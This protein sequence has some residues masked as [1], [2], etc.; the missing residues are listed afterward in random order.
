MIHP[1]TRARAAGRARRFAAAAVLGVAAAGCGLWAPLRES[2]EP[3]TPRPT[4]TLER[5]DALSEA[6]K[7]TATAGADQ[8][9]PGEQ[10][11][12]PGTNEAYPADQRAAGGTDEAHPPGYPPPRPTAGPTVDVKAT[13]ESRRVAIAGVLPVGAQFDLDDLADWSSIEPDL[14]ALPFQHA[15]GVPDLA[16]VDTGAP[17][18]VWRLGGAMTYDAPA[19]AGA[20]VIAPDRKGLPAILLRGDAS[21]LVIVEPDG[22]SITA[23]LPLEW[24][25]AERARFETSELDFDGDR[26]AE[27]LLRVYEPTSDSSGYDA[28]FVV[29]RQVEEGRALPLFRS[30]K[31][32]RIRHRE[33]D[34]RPELIVPQDDG[35]WSVLALSEDGFEP[36]GTLAWTSVAQATANPE[37]LEPIPHDLY[38]YR[39]EQHAIYRWPAEGGVA[40]RVVPGPDPTE[41]ALVELFGDR[42]PFDQIYRAARHADVVAYV[43][44]SPKDPAAAEAFGFRGVAAPQAVTETI[45]GSLGQWDLSPDGKRI[46]YA[47]RGALSRGN[48]TRHAYDADDA[49]LTLLDRG[50]RPMTR[51]IARCEPVSGAT[52]EDHWRIRCSTFAVNDDWTRVAYSDGNGLWVVDLPDGVPRRLLAHRIGGNSASGW[53]VY[54]PAAWSPD[55]KWILLDV[56]HYEGS[57]AVLLNVESGGLVPV[58]SSSSYSEYGASFV[59]SADS[60]FVVVAR[61]GQGPPLSVLDLATA[62]DSAT[63]ADLSGLDFG[64]DGYEPVVSESGKI[65]F[66]LATSDRAYPGTGLFELDDGGVLRRLAPGPYRSGWSSDYVVWNGT[67][68]AVLL[69]YDDNGWI[70]SGTLWSEHLPETLDISEVLKGAR[71]PQWGAGRR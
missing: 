25:I 53:H 66:G 68:S 18:L 54:R 5:A 57:S 36:A 40:R 42:P 21:E 31:G 11:A 17:R 71:W 28:T 41:W 59:F 48:D 49:M 63:S 3:P 14:R 2:G 70:E 24:T 19:V 30:P 50:A 35:S 7:Q 33:G 4:D 23:R 44:G 65:R 6:L 26:I 29:Y 56:G 37:S 12:T 46:L 8:A 13:A 61:W 20:W 27:R 22:W 55:S 64:P 34:D 62:V 15:D 69:A 10:L 45:R 58:P 39:P 32:T 38:L 67:E 52:E 47:A 16:V 1:S 60:R 43:L 51:S 9:Y